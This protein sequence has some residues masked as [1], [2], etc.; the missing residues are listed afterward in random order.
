[1]NDL[2][3]H[4]P[5]YEWDIARCDLRQW[6]D[7]GHSAKVGKRRCVWIMNWPPLYVTVVPH[8]WCCRWCG[9]LVS[10]WWFWRYESIFQLIPRSPIKKQVIK[11]KIDREIWDQ[12]WPNREKSI[13]IRDFASPWKS[14]GEKWGVFTSS[15]IWYSCFIISVRLKLKY[16]RY[17]SV[18]H[19]HSYNHVLSGAEARGRGVNRPVLYWSICMLSYGRRS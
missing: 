6:P 4:Y 14:G 7:D 16:V 2:L 3:G 12:R 10:G 11:R 15:R 1:M 17:C 19:Y 13:S 18:C 5:N 9:T 8:V